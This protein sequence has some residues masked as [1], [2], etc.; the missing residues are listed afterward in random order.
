MY[1]MPL[2]R[3]KDGTYRVFME[4]TSL[5]GRDSRRLTF[6]ECKKRAYKRMQFH[7]MNVLDIEEEEY[8]Y[9]PMGGELPDRTQRIVAF[10]AAA[11]MV[12]PSTGYQA[13]RMLA[14]STEVA[15][16]IGHGL[17]TNQPPDQIASLAY[18]ALWNKK[19]RRQRDFQA[20]GG[21]FLMAQ[22]VEKLRGFFMAFFAIDQPVWSGF[23]AGYPGLPGNE[24]H[25]DWKSRLSFAMKFFFELKTE[26]KICMILFSIKHT[27]EYGPNTLVR[28]LLPDFLLWSVED[29]PGWQPPP[30]T[31]GA[32]EA[33]DEA[34]KMIIEFAKS[35]ATKAKQTS[36]LAATDAMDYPAPFENIL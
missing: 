29:D 34:R 15:K 14:A 13:C 8:C 11:N 17:K 1:V 22:P 26:V 35:K 21:D 20:F 31:M 16:V 27:Y 2:S 32:V 7:G 5:V 30:T 3:N 19:I 9:I 10:G 33:K 25:E 24:N 4:E 23:L 36:A 6:E 18:N 12:H 28:T